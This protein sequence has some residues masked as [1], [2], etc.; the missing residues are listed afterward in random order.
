M[1]ITIRGHNLPGRAFC[2]AE[3]VPYDN[4]HVA[5]QEGRDPVGMVAG[6]A[7]SA[8]WHVEVR[9]QLDASGEVDFKG[10][11]V[12]GKRGDRFLYLTW[13]DV[14]D[15]GSFEMFRRAKLMLNRIDADLV[16]Q[17]E[18]RHQPLVA[19]V[20]LSD[21]CG[22]PRCARVDPPALAWALE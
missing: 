5:V 1:R 15:D 17:A 11:V 3:G 20:D 12:H 7:A 4:V 9:T 8:E 21:R 2:N 16:G 19:S 22:A 6:D 18:Q 13:G 10:T 14:G